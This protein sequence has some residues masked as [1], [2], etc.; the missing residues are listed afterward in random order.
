MI[1]THAP[2]RG[3]TQGQCER[4]LKQKDFNPRS[5][6]GSDEYHI[7]NRCIFGHFNPRSRKGSDDTAIPF[8]LLAKL[9]STHAPARGATRLNRV[10]L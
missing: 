3:A 4:M 6:K 10:L 1:S 2:A 7:S 8:I 5:R 9:I